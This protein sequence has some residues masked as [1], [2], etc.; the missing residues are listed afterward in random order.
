MTGGHEPAG[1]GPAGQSP[2][3]GFSD[4]EP[5]RRLLRSRP[6]RLSLAW[7]GAAAQAR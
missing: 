5:T 1:P 6:P 2:A 4:D 7:A 3:H